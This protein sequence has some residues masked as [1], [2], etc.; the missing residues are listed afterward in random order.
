MLERRLNLSVFP[1]LEANP[2]VRLLALGAKATGKDRIVE[3]EFDT[4]KARSRPDKIQALA[5]KASLGGS[6]FVLEGPPGTGKTQTI[7]AMVE[8]LAKQAGKRVLV[9]AAMPGAVGVIHRRLHGVVPHD[10]CS[11]RRGQIDLAGPTVALERYA[12][13]LNVVIGTP[14]GL[15]SD[16]AADDKYDV[17]IID[18]ASQMRLSHALA[19][20]GHASQIIVAG[21]SRQL[22]PR[23]SEVG[24]ITESSLLARAR[25]AGLP[26]VMLERHYR[27]Q[28]P[29][30][31]AW[32]NAFSYESKL[33][34]NLGPYL[35]GDA[36]FDVA[37]VRPGRRLQRDLAQVN[38]EEAEA[39]AAE[40]L[41]WARDGRRTVGVAAL[42]QGQRD[43]IRETV[44]RELGKAG[45]S[46]ATAGPD[47][48]FFSKEEPFFIRTAGAVQGEERDVMMVSL[49]VAPNAEGKISQNTGALSRPDGLA[50]ANVLLSR[51]RLR[52]VVYCSILPWEI[53]LAA[54]T[55]G[56][57]LI[58]SI[59]RMATV[60]AA[61]DRV[62]DEP[63]H[64]NFI[65]P[66]WT[67]HR[68]EVAGEPVIGFIHRDI[69]DRYALGVSFLKNSER[70]PAFY[71]LVQS[72]W[73]MDYGDI[74]SLTS[75]DASLRRDI[76]VAMAKVLAPVDKKSERAAVQRRLS[77]SP[78]CETA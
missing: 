76:G 67:A 41:K 5:V 6:S 61:P 49:G 57:F 77:C 56:M 7:V 75:D 17:L 42:T 2:V 18:E 9:S 70:S 43:L 44:E 22:Q 13:K 68:L 35:L 45:L 21:D 62:V 65:F 8:A 20:C 58:A 23:D 74:S 32:S 55:P 12:D 64:D 53:N 26:V 40:C 78:V 24:A 51:A 47:N 14:M 3:G 63:I 54:M 34:P 72:G 31:I 33:K 36:G 71:L 29:S 37:Y 39:I 38:V 1:D 60:V 30:L 4:Q 46:A 66:D 10:I 11:L 16:L 52:T 27:S 50:V 69:P 28:H 15:I 59:L 73:E 25:L 19:L 48:R